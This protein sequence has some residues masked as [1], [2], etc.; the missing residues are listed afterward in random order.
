MDVSKDVSTEIQ[1][2]Y[3]EI[4][5]RNFPVS[6]DLATHDGLLASVSNAD[7]LVYVAILLSF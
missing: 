5:L 6:I 7:D 2:S 3:L 4:P 1:I